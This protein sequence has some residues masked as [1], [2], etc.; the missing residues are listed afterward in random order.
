MGSCHPQ[1]YS[2]LKLGTAIYGNLRDFL[3]KL[4][5][6]PTITCW[7]SSG[8]KWLSP[9]FSH[10]KAAYRSHS[11]TKRAAVSYAAWQWLLYGIST[12]SLYLSVGSDKHVP[13][14]LLY[15]T[16]W[17][18]CRGSLIR[19]WTLNT[20][21]TKRCNRNIYVQ[22]RHNMARKEVCF[23]AASLAPKAEHITSL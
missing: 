13:T 7:K 3:I 11:P 20:I 10:L 8:C 22:S 4:T 12:T 15:T 17:S 2:Q 14:S 5:R 19:Q 1:E 18:S 6:S 9:D 23:Q 21:T 16:S